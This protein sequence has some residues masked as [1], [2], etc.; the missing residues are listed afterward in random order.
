MIGDKPLDILMT[1]QPDAPETDDNDDSGRASKTRQ[2]KQMQALQDL[3]VRLTELNRSQ[4]AG[5][6][7]TPELEKA[8]QD[9]HQITKREALRRHRQYIGK[10]MRNADHDAIA[11]AVSHISE[12][13]NRM[14]R[15][16]HVMEKWRDDLIEGDQQ[17]LEA[18]IE[19]F[20]QVDRQHLRQLVQN[21]RQERLKQKPPVS[22]R[23]LFAVV[24]EQLELQMDNSDQSD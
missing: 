22:A 13:Q 24:R 19:Q 23:K 2:K 10:L 15:L 9:S 20:P 18:F 16:F 7:L 4:L 12:K 3:G 6:P 17:Q 21:A 5:L 8:I 11:I 14:A 1:Q